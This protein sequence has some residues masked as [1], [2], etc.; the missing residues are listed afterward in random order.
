[1]DLGLTGQGGES[2]ASGEQGRILCLNV[3]GQPSDA[4][5][6]SYWRK[7]KG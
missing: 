4:L 7:E 5:A 1:M 6:V 3:L 2:V